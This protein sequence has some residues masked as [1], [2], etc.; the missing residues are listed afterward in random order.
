MKTPTLEKDIKKSI[1]EYSKKIPGL[2]LFHYSAYLGEA[3]IPDYIGVYH[4]LFV[5]VEVKK[6]G[7][8]PTEKQLQKH[9]QLEMHGA[10]ITIAYCLQDF[11]NFIKKLEKYRRV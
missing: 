1:K 8:K 5:G 2:Y 7:N 6:P 10:F 9:R 3:G 11:I 4:G